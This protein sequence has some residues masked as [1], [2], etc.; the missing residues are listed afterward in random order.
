MSALIDEHITPLL[1]AL[2]PQLTMIR[3]DIHKHPELGFEEHRTQRLVMGWLEKLGYQP[4]AMAGT[5][6]VADLRPDLVGQAPTVALRAD[7]DC[8]PMQE[9]SELPYC[10][11]HDGRAHKC[12]HDGHTTI[13]LGV[14]A[15]L[16]NLRDKLGDRLAGN[17]RLIFQPAEEGVDGGGAKVMLD[18][19]V[20]DQVSEIY[21]LHNWP[22]F[23]LGQVHV[24]TGPTMAQV[25]DL[26][27]EIQ[28]RGGHGSQPQVC[29]DPVVAGAAL[30]GELQ[31][32]VSRNLG[33]E[34]GAV[35]SVCTFHA[36]EANNVIPER[37][38]LTGT[39]RT[40]DPR[41]TERVVARI[42]QIARGVAESHGV[43][44][45]AHVEP[46]YPV[47]QNAA[48]CAAAVG[49]VAETLLGPESCSSAGLPLAA[50]EDFG[51]FAAAV[52]GAYFFLGAGRDEDTPGCHHPDFDFDDR[53]IPTGIRMFVGIVADRLGLDPG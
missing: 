34:G 25:H 49:R 10:S 19:G 42:E 4:Q 27:F 37:A 14:A 29:I 30:V 7:L 2:V 36:G 5:G 52:P 32:I 50:G 28:G 44:I 20:L 51:Y 21:G 22:G 15:V 18:E 38:T 31:T 24:C 8:L 17:V 43:Q 40:F 3:H 11:I 16:A 23:A 39:L 12:G 35:L 1:D 48:D 53:L 33:Y 6:V 45:H 13:M 26:A 9:H 41:V 47:L 46:Q